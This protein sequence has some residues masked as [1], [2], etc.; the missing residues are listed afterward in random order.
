MKKRFFLIIVTALLFCQSI[1]CTVYGAEIP[2]V[3]YQR[4]SFEGKQYEYNSQITAIMFAGIDS[5]DELTT[6]NRYSIAPRADTI[7]LL[8]LDNYRKQMR[9]LAI[10][11]DTVTEIQRFAMNGVSR[12]YYDTQIGYAFSYGDGGKK[13][14]ENLT[15]AVSSLLGGVPVHEYVVINNPTI[16]KAN[17]MAGG[18]TVTVPNDDL[19]KMDE[20]MKAGNTMTLDSSMAEM[21]V[22][23][24]DTE[25][26]FSNNGRM[27]RQK[28]YL[29]AYLE[30]MKEMVSENPEQTWNEIES[31]KGSMITSITKNQYLKLAG[32]LKEESLSEEECYSL[33]GQDIQGEVH[34]LLYP[35]E[36]QLQ[37]M[38]VDLFYLEV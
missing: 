34:D 12:G 6:Y 25:V 22:R 17:E 35:D 10:S 1:L 29:K 15:D 7:D 13:S 31:M 27:E 30:K 18:I 37:Q 4:I 38:I 23:Y 19:I 33:P 11:R 28:V 5:G 3:G 32:F 2:D 20:R 14:C 16:A 8:I 36:Q 26:P 9:L 21:F 24:R